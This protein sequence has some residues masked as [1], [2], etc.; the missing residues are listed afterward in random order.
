[1]RSSPLVFIPL[2]SVQMGVNGFFALVATKADSAKELLLDSSSVVGKRLGVDAPVLLHR[3][4]AAHPFEWSYLLYITEN[5]MWLRALRCCVV[6]VFDGAASR[7]AKRAET[8]KRT[9]RKLEQQEA[10]VQWQ[11]RLE[12]ASN[13]SDIE[14]CRAKVE[15]CTRASVSIGDAERNYMKRLI[16]SLGFAW[17][18][19]PGEAEQFLATLQMSGRIDEIITEDSDA[20]I[21]GASSIIRNFWDLRNKREDASV[22]PQRV[23]RE[24]V[25]RSLEVSDHQMRLAA[26][27]AGCD[28]APKVKNVGLVKAL[29]V[30]RKESTVLACLRSLTKEGVDDKQDLLATY[31][32][33]MALLSPSSCG[34][35]SH[36]R[37]SLE[38]IDR[39]A[40]D[41]LVNEVEAAGE[42]WAL[43][44][45]L[46]V[47]SHISFELLVP[48]AWLAAES[49]PVIFASRIND[50]CTSTT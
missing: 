20:L 39:E 27:L 43:R 22:H 7:E 4:R 48:A 44:S 50:R 33:A 49:P 1:M 29:K 11:A 28:F 42:P 6:F 9:Q 37:A 47:I 40:L 5:L 38:D 30:A 21:C 14:Q 2:G 16:S 34:S 24:V 26:V 36:T 31:E 15:Q 23:H 18:E 45:A 3:A 25:L 10:L 46:T 8:S 12:N 17:Q 35:I 19:A 41:A 13:W 32:R